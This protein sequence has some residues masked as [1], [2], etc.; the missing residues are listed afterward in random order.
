MKTH[1]KALVVGG[2]AVGT[3]IA[4][5]L[6]R[7]GWEDVVLLERN[8]LTSGTTWHSAAQVT[9]F[10]MNQTM[11]GLKTHSINLYKELANEPDHPI[12]Y[13][14]SDGGIRLANTEEQ[15]QGYRHFASMAKGMGVDFE[16]IE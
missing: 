14:H 12:N 16:V 3:S 11:I 7:A 4:Y 6:A 15:M 9:N 1:V 2:G 10:G 13:N 5:H 8:D